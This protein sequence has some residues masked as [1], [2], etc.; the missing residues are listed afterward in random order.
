MAHYARVNLENIVTH[1]TPVPNEI[2]TDENGVEH[3]HRALAHLYSTIPDSANDRWIQTSYN[4][5]FRVRYA[6]LGFI[7]NDQ[8]NAF[9]PPKPH[10][11]W[12]LNEET[13]DWDAPV[14]YPTDGERYTWNEEDQ[15]WTEQP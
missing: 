12:V 15:E 2:I 10:E 14:P 13:F 8:L 7:W 9:I 4:N 6:G 5:N 3:E 1:V 11:S